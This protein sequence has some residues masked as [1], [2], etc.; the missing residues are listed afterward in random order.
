[1]LMLDNRGVGRSG[2]PQAKAA[3]TTTIMATD[4]LLLLVRPTPQ[5]FFAIVSQAHLSNLRMV[6]QV[7]GKSGDG[8]GWT[9]SDAFK[10]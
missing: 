5:Y 9:F 8:S 2:C 6:L 10:L 4:V 1:V 7:F 3:Y